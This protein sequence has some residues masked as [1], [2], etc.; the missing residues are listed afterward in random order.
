MNSVH[1]SKAA[2][3]MAATTLGLTLGLIGATPAI[4][5][6]GTPSGESATPAPPP[7]ALDTAGRDRWTTAPVADESVVWDASIASRYPS[8]RV[9]QLAGGLKAQWAG[10]ANVA[11]TTTVE[12]FT[13]FAWPP[14]V[15]RAESA[16]LAIPGSLAAGREGVALFEARDAAQTGEV[17]SEDAATSSATLSARTLALADTALASG[18]VGVPP[19][20]MGDCRFVALTTGGDLLVL[21][22]SA[23]TVSRVKNFVAAVPDRDEWTWGLAL[24]AMD[25][26]VIAA[27]PDG[28]IARVT[29][30]GG[31]VNRAILSDIA[32]GPFVFEPDAVWFVTRDGLLSRWAKADRA[33]VAIARGA[34]PVWNGPVA[35]SID[36]TPAL[37]WVGGAGDLQLYAE[38]Q[39]ISPD[40]LGVAVKSPLM[41]ADMAHTGRAQLIASTADGRLAAISLSTLPTLPTGNAAPS[42]VAG[43]IWLPV[44]QRTSRPAVIAAAGAGE[45]T[46]VLLAA[47]RSAGVLLQADGVRAARI[48]L[49]QAVLAPGL[50]WFDA[51]PAAA[52]TA[53]LAWT[54]L[55]ASPAPT[56]DNTPAN[57][58]DTTPP[59]TLDP[60]PGTP[61]GT[62]AAATPASDNG[63]MEL[64]CS[65][66]GHHDRASPVASA[67]MLLALTAWA[68][69]R[70][71]G[72]RAV[73][74]RARLSHPC[75]TTVG[76]PVAY[77]LAEVES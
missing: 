60:T 6:E 43:T 33:P 70:E 74:E 57:T 16:F 25:G 64:G 50:R 15:C 46:R 54:A 38:G 17:R 55:A 61:A 2:A 39:L 51:G 63:P 18:W 31:A 34:A 40:S 45:P 67:V 13:A 36:A 29:L 47:G 52:Q 62:D 68:L 37:A 32:V 59:A 77:S 9:S 4:A 41:V 10:A 7:T 3:R 53:P 27:S 12:G 72:R 69:R 76:P 42:F 65:A 20:A 49:N 5:G 21:S 22:A 24:G 30:D 71:T 56:P 28:Q 48:D 14:G 11:G 26:T 75:L 8:L 66:K 19:T 1:F 35:L 44:T 23:G 58:P 73:H